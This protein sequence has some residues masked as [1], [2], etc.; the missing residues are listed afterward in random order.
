VDR[1]KFTEQRNTKKRSLRSDLLESFIGKSITVIYATRWDGYGL[2]KT[3]VLSRLPFDFPA[4]VVQTV[5]QPFEDLLPM[6]V[7]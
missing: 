7:L 2:G 1:L 4:F 6:Y 3:Q 5:S